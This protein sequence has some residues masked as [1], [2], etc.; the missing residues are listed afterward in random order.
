[1]GDLFQ[2][3]QPMHL[4]KLAKSENDMNYLQIRKWR[5]QIGVS[6]TKAAELLGVDLKTYISWELGD[7][8]I[9]QSVANACANLNAR[10]S[11]TG[12]QHKA[13][14]DNIDKYK[15]AYKV[16]FGKEPIGKHLVPAEWF[17]GGFKAIDFSPNDI[18]IQ[19]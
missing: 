15:K 3:C 16:Y 5:N 11:G 6:Q 19:N 2:L 4:A 9:S 7:K 10:Y 17:T 13:L 1:M 8:P 14:I 18:A 12:G